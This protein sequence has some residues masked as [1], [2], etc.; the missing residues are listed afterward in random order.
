MKIT[1]IKLPADFIPSDRL[2]ADRA[3][4]RVADLV[5]KH[6]RKK[7]GLPRPNPFGMPKS[8]YYADAAETVLYE[9]NGNRFEVSVGTESGDPDAKGIG[10][11]LHYEGGR[12]SPKN[13]K[14]LAIPID[15]KVADIWP[16]EYA[17]G[18]DDALFFTPAGAV[19]DRKTGE[20]LWLLVPH[21][22]IPAD[23]TVLPTDEEIN[24]AAKLGI[25][26]VWA[27]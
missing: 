13:H 5:Q 16:S 3:A 2:T 21:A 18:D 9:A 24:N 20:I 4:V 11:A 7:N 26:E 6:L 8:D 27:A 19:G 14:H 22:D 25:G 15:P 1:R 23:P 17:N 12:V 10:I